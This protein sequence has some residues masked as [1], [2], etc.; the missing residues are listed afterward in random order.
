[1]TTVHTDTQTAPGVAPSVETAHTHLTAPLVGTVAAGKGSRKIKAKKEKRTRRLPILPL[2]RQVSGAGVEEVLDPRHVGD[3]LETSCVVETNNA[4]CE[5]IDFLRV[6]K[7]GIIFDDPDWIAEALEPIRGGGNPLSIA[8]EYYAWREARRVFIGQ[9][10]DYIAYVETDE[11]RREKAEKD[12]GLL[13]PLQMGGAENRPSIVAGRERLLSRLTGIAGYMTT[14]RGE[15]EADDLLDRLGDMPGLKQLPGDYEEALRT[16]GALLFDDKLGDVDKVSRALEIRVA[17]QIAATYLD[18]PML[19]S[20]ENKLLVAAA[21]AVGR[22]RGTENMEEPR[23]YEDAPSPDR[24]CPISP[25][26]EIGQP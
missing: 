20:H 9:L 4:E 25:M 22:M 5:L 1:M 12:I 16:F 2:L 19:G 6:G 14:Q 11:A 10:Q 18:A 13:Q 17:L 8:R 26:G 23:L 15:W 21:V 24:Y 3:N 7:P